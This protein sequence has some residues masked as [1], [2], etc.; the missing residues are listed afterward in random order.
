M[1]VTSPEGRVLALAIVSQGVDAAVLHPM[2]KYGCAN[3]L[4]RS[5]VGTISRDTD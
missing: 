3:W 5:P 1:G 2:I 4:V